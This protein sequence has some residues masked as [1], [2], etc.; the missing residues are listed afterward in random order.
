LSPEATE[1][2]RTVARD[3]LINAGAQGRNI[4]LTVPPEIET[5]HNE[6]ELSFHADGFPSH[7]SAAEA[8]SLDVRDKTA[9]AALRRARARDLALWRGFLGLIALLILLGLGELALV[10][11]GLRSAA[12]LTQVNAQRPV[13]DKIETAQN[14]TTRINELSTKRLLPFEMMAIV[15]DKKPEVVMFL[16]TSTSGLDNLTVEAQSTSPGAVSA[17]QAALSANPALEKVEIR[18]QR[19]RDNIMN[20]TL[21]VTFRP[22]ALKPAVSTP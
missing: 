14:L 6:R 3:E 21:A 13:V 2:E 17:Y 16:R 20:F 19:T 10:G 9:L 8:G 4:V 7:L 15:S 22:E 12:Q 5:S 1:A 18:D 11:I